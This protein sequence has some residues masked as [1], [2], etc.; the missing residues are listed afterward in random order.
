[1]VG[2]MVIC[3][4]V[5]IVRVASIMGVYE[6][7]KESKDAS[8]ICFSE[9]F[10]IRIK[11]I[12]TYN[13]NHSHRA[14]PGRLQRHGYRLIFLLPCLS[15]SQP[16]MQTG[17]VHEKQFLPTGPQ[18]LNSSYELQLLTLYALGVFCLVNEMHVSLREAD[19]LAAIEALQARNT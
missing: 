9:A 11:R 19:L 18:A 13:A 6:G 14:T 8:L 17:F 5:K 7:I 10:E 16:R 12:T 1:M 2:S 3:Y 15:F 4:D